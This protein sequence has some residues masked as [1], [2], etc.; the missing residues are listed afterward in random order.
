MEFWVAP[1][2]GVP[3]FSGAGFWIT[4]NLV[5]TAHC[6]NLPYALESTGQ[7]TNRDMKVFELPS[8]SDIAGLVIASSATAVTCN[9][10]GIVILGTGGDPSYFTVSPT[11]R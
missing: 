10:P 5:L 8:V 9:R 7:R 1:E 4:Y 11:I 2:L 6:P 3:R